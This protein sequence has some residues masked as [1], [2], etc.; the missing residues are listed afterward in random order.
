MFHPDGGSRGLSKRENYVKYRQICLVA[1]ERTSAI[2]SSEGQPRMR[3]MMA[4]QG[5]ADG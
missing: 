1:S 5:E 3:M 2:A 4:A